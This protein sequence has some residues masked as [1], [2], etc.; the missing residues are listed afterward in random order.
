MV[1][2][3]PEVLELEELG[4]GRYAA[5]N[6]VDDPEGRDVVF[7]GQILAQMIMAADRAVEGAKDVKSIHAI[8]ARAGT[9]S[10]GPM[11][12]ELESLHS[13]R[14]W[15]SDTITARQGDRLLSRALVLLN[16]IEPDLIRHGPEMPAVPMPDDLAPDPRA[17]VY[18]GIETR[19]VADPDATTGD[20]SPAMYF[21]MR[22]RE[23]Y[24][25]QA[26][27]QAILAWSQPGMLIGL[28]MRPHADAVSIDDAHRSISTG[29][30]AHT[31]RFH[32]RF[33]IGQWLL[34]AQEATYAGRG[35]VN[36]RGAVF[37]EAGQLVATFEQDSMVRGVQGEL[38][39]RR[40]M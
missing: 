21:W 1:A 8:F 25:S 15:G 24:E 10:G 32:E 22:N 5:P 9:Y 31:S 4:N 11:E 2:T 16:T 38:D 13:G 27:N 39:P 33:D 12:L 19:T 35:R 14:A 18:P 28:A 37:T 20:G 29:V 30:I 3:V 34:V 26:V 7:S 17:L 6:P 23:S 40:S 36:G